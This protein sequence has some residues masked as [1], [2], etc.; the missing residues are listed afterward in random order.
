MSH[1]PEIDDGIL[2]FAWVYF[3]VELKRGPDPTQLLGPGEELA[4]NIPNTR[5]MG[6]W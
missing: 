2:E 3:K 4:G 6:S 5:T 1:F